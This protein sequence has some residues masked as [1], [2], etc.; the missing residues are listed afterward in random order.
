MDPQA[1]LSLTSCV[2]L[3][4]VNTGKVNKVN[5][6]GHLSRVCSVLRVTCW[7]VAESQGGPGDTLV[8]G[9]EGVS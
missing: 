7:Y 9:Q 5:N 6:I 3:E 2:S 1:S 8:G 4:Q